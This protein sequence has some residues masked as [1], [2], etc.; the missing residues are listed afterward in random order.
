ME[1]G[2]MLSQASIVALVSL[3][4]AL[5]PLPLGILYA[6]RPSEARLALLRPVA[7][8]SMFGA[9]TGTMTG[10]LNVLRGIALRDLPPTLGQMAAGLAEALVPIFVA[11]A[12]LTVAWLG[13]AVGFKRQERPE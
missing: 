7:L 13:V 9:L 3:V 4:V 5:G 8:A 2:Q 1:F 11:C 6:V 12:S 10:L